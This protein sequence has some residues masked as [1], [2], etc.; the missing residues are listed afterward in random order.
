MPPLNNSMQKC[1]YVQNDENKMDE[2]LNPHLDNKHSFS[3]SYFHG[4]PILDAETI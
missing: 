3:V 2:I 1:T 4:K